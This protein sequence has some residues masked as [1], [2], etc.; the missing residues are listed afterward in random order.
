MSWYYLNGTQCAAK[1]AQRPG[2]HG[3]TYVDGCQL[4]AKP[5]AEGDVDLISKV[6]IAGGTVFMAR[7]DRDHDEQVSPRY[8]KIVRRN[9]KVMDV[10]D[11]ISTSITKSPQT[12][13]V[14]LRG[15]ELSST[16][17]LDCLGRWA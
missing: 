13:S 7:T 15:L 8:Y 5:G 11:A 9:D 1:V 16:I 14:E 3:R 12:C 6:N 2:E 4:S 17:W 10:P